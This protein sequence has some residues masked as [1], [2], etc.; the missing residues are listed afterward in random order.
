[1]HKICIYWNTILLNNLSFR[2]KSKLKKKKN[3]QNRHFGVKGV[4][5]GRAPAIPNFFFKKMT[6]LSGAAD[7]LNKNCKIQSH[8]QNFF[9]AGNFVR[10]TLTKE[11]FLPFLPGGPIMPNFL[12]NRVREEKEKK[13]FLQIGVGDKMILGSGECQFRNPV[14]QSNIF[15]FFRKGIRKKSH[16]PYTYDNKIC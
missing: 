10:A 14:H 2:I 6:K 5:G 12:E 11:R 8:L 1:M 9:E 4:G 3:Y 13:G 7:T 15:F 16:R